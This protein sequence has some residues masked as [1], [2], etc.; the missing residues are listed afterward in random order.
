MTIIASFQHKVYWLLVGDLLISGIEGINSVQLP[1]RYHK[2]Q[3]ATP[4]HFVGL[5]QK[6][7]CVDDNLAVAWAGSKIV[8]QHLIRRIANELSPPY[9]SDE[10]L[11]LIYDS[12]LLEKEL[13]SVSF[14]FFGVD[15]DKQT[16]E[17]HQFIQDYLTGETILDKD[18]KVKYAGSGQYHFLESLQYRMKGYEGAITEFEH[19][20]ALLISRIGIALFT[21]I[22]SDETHNFS[23]GGGFEI[24][25]LDSRK[26]MAKLPIT[27]VFWSL[28]KEGPELIG[29]ILAFNYPQR[30]HLL[31]SRL[32][33]STD[34]SEWQLSQFAVADILANKPIEPPYD[35]PDFDTFF[36]MH[37]FIQESDERAIQVMIEKGEGKSVRIDISP[38]GTIFNLIR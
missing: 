2:D 9:S 26:K 3:P 18:T 31:I 17:V 25:C 30:N 20:I 24:A 37:Y 27:F 32:S 22:I 12:G 6:V 11:R 1:T 8:A 5:S 19:W 16:G 28:K 15:H 23:Y 4:S 13:N 10:I 29:P 21:E 34:S 14:I 35:L 38:D 36:T 33:Q 7:V